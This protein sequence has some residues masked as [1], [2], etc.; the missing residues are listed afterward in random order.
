MILY[1]YKILKILNNNNLKQLLWLEQVV[2]EKYW[3]R[4]ELSGEN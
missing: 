1:V 2:S 4:R 3:P